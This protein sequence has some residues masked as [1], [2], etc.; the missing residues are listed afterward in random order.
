V[1]H[2][3]HNGDPCPNWKPSYWQ[4]EFLPRTVAEPEQ[5]ESVPAS[6]TS[7][8]NPPCRDHGT[9]PD[10]PFMATG[11]EAP[12]SDDESV[13]LESVPDMDSLPTNAMP[14]QAKIF[15]ENDADIWTHRRDIDGNSILVVV[16]KS[17]LHPLP[18]VFCSCHGAPTEDIQ[19][20]DLGLFPA[21][22]E[23]IRTVFSFQVLDD[24]LADNQECKTSAMHYFHKLRRFTNPCFPMTAPVSIFS[25]L[26]VGL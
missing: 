19:C 26:G 2:L 4:S 22:F 21:S 25:S 16:D 13:D 9:V 10:D 11:D 23:R 18:V 7:T 17:G 1:L 20:L 14:E 24:Y 6:G 3:G 5:V 15:F 8:D 12:A